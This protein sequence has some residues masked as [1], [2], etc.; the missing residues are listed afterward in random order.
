VHDFFDILGLPSTAPPSE[1][2]WVCARRVRRTHPDFRTS[3][4]A[5]SAAPVNTADPTREIFEVAIDF[6]EMDTFIDRMQ[7]AFFS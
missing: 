7:S 4:G 1:V 5:T 6:V 3:G 2:R